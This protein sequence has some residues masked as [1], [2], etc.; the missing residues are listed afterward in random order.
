M[1]APSGISDMPYASKKPRSSERIVFAT[2][3]IVTTRPNAP[4]AT[5]ES[6]EQAA[7][8][9][10]RSV[11]SMS[12]HRCPSKRP[13]PPPSDTTHVAS[14]LAQPAVS[15]CWK[16]SGPVSGSGVAVGADVGTGV[17]IGVGVGRVTI[18]AAAPAPIAITSMTAATAAAAAV[19]VAAAAPE[20]R[21]PHPVREECHRSDE[22]GDEDHD[23]NVAVPD[24]RQL[25][26]D[27]AL[28]LRAI[29]LVEKAARHDD[30]RVLWVAAGRECIRRG[31]LDHVEPRRGDAQADRERLD[32]VVQLLLLVGSELA[33][34]ALRE[35]EPVPGEVRRERAPDREREREGQHGRTAAGREV[36]AHEVAEDNDERGEGGDER[37]RPPPVRRGGVVDR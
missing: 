33:C 2:S 35:D 28:E 15:G 25:V 14:S 30:R 21:P 4:I 1:I 34:L 29:K 23:S 19:A 5:T 10:E 8:T 17:G 13:I 26:R 36:L 32:D 3:S 20:H 37:D 31:V 22:D 11:E 24:V 9:N 7:A 27:H 16:T 18:P 6:G 12:C